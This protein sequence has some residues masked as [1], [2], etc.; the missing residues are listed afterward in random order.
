MYRFK[1]KTIIF[2]FAVIFYSSHANAGL[3]SSLDD[4]LSSLVKNSARYLVTVKGEDG[5]SNLIATGI[6]FNED[7][8]LIT[9]SQTFTADNFEVTFKSGESY[10]ADRVGVDHET[11]LAV[12]KI[13]SDKKFKTPKFGKDS[14]IKQ[15]DWILVVGN[16]YDKPATVNVGTFDG[17]DEDGLYNLAINISPGSSGG[18]VMN[19]DGEIIAVIVAKEN[20]FGGLNSNTH[21]KVF[22]DYFVFNSADW[23]VDNALAVPYDKVKDIA[24][25]LIE[26]GE[27]KRGFL[28][29]SQKNLSKSH[30]EKHKIDGG[31]IIVNIVHNSPAE[32]AG[33][34]EDDIIIKIDNKKIEG[35]TDLYNQIRSHRPGDE[36]SLIYIRNGKSKM[37]N[38]ELADSRK[39]YF[40]GSWDIAKNLP[41]LKISNKLLIQDTDELEEELHD[42]KDEIDRLRDEMNSLRKEFEN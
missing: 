37:V 30:K 9:S 11:G 22:K 12:L 3:L 25:Q 24:E 7:G 27:I 33:L 17:I 5:L 23:S 16:S 1:L 42:L 19:T 35:T 18:A 29:I 34:R 20:F 2:L 6:V 10:N 14:Q 28:G 39:D 26:Y 38:I 32:E 8:Y 4:E 36:I 21:K 41:K 13:K 31:T 40:L 15:G